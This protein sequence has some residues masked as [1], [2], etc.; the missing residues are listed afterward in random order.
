MHSCI[1]QL[2]YHEVSPLY[3]S[4]GKVLVLSKK[5]QYDIYLYIFEEKYG[6]THW[7]QN[8]V[9]VQDIIRAPV[10]SLENR[11]NITLPV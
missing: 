1:N 3:T 11:D 8:F 5:A 7:N 10:H 2:F 6:E 4:L 9:P